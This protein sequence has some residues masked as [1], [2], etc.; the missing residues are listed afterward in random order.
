MAARWGL[1]TGLIVGLVG[2]A[3]TGQPG[4]PATDGRTES[5]EAAVTQQPFTSA[6]PRSAS[7]TVALPELLPASLD[8]VEL[9]TFAVG[10][11]ILDRLAPTL[12]VEPTAI[13]AAYASEH[14]ARFFQSYAI[15]VPG[16][17]GSRLLE[18]FAASAYDPSEGEVTADEASVGGRSVTV[19]T[20]SATAARLGTFYAYLMDDV[21]LVVQAFDPVV[22]DEVVS[23]LP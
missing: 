23:A 22:A 3:P 14:G 6:S 11:D 15:R 8:G 13:E 4:A 1:I 5:P 12:G 9:H 19:V 21:L 7:P 2:C 10:G 17:E 20:Q 16:V 18:A